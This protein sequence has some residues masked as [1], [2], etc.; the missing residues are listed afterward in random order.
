M[1][2]IKGALEPNHPGSSSTHSLVSHIFCLWAHPLR[3]FKQLQ[4]AITEGWSSKGFLGPTA[5][6]RPTAGQTSWT[7]FLPRGSLGQGKMKPRERDGGLS[8][9]S[10][11][12]EVHTQGWGVTSASIF[13]VFWLR[14]LFSH[15]GHSQARLPVFIS[16]WLPSG[17]SSLENLLT[18]TSVATIAI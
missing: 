9:M 8:R 13:V 18:F 17:I 16:L 6:N 12:A 2:N 14:F 11:T 4:A 7:C 1:W 5:C 10:L 3:I 15:S